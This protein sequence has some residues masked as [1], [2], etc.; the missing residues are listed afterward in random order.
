MH[1]IKRRGFLR[2]GF[3]FSTVPITG[4]G[5]GAAGGVGEAAPAPIAASPPPAVAASAAPA[6]VAAPAPGPAATGSMA[7]SLLTTAAA[8]AA[9]FCIGF[10]FRKGDVP[11]AQSVV[12]D[13]AHLQVTPKNRWPD[14]S[15]KFAVVAGRAALA[16]NT[17]STIALRAGSAAPGVDLTLADLKA[18]GVTAA[19]DGAAFGAASWAGTAWDAP[20]SNWISGPEMSSWIYRKPVGSDAHLVAWLEVRLYAGGAVEVLPWIENGYLKVA[21][22]VNKA[23]VFSFSLGGVLR[24]SAAI[25]LPARA[26]TPLLSG[27]A[28]SHWLGADPAIAARH[29]VDYLQAT[30]AVPAYR[31]VVAPDSA[32]VTGLVATYEPLQKGNFDYNADT[33]S[34]GG[35]ASPIGLLPQHD[36]LYLVANSMSIGAAVQRNGYGAGRY[37][38]HYRDEATN[39]PLRFSAHATT[40]TNYSSTGSYPARATGTAAAQWDVAHSPSVG[41]MAY[42]LSGRYFFMEEVQFAATGNYLFSTDGVRNGADGWFEPV[43]GGVQVRQCAWAFRTLAQ[44][45]AVTPDGDAT[46]QGEFKASVEANI[47]R[48]HSR[49]VAASNNPFGMIEPDYD[50]G[51]PGVY[52]AAGWMQDFFTAAYGYA[53]AM[54]LPISATAQTQLAAFFAWKAQSIIGRLGSSADYWY[55]NAA[56]YN[57]AVA[58]SDT[59]NFGAGTGPWYS[60]W[61]QIYDAT[62]AAAA[63]GQQAAFGTTEGRLSAEILP[64]ADSMWGNLQPAIAYAV[65][66]GV[67]GAAAAY[68]RMTSASNWPALAAQLNA[69]PVW[70]VKPLQ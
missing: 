45:L 56:T 30:E 67:A 34:S 48:F 18:A 55:L 62:A 31:A 42:L 70:S 43:P 47:A 68:Q 9:P 20:F 59:P 16:A 49:Y 41:Y 36:A 44:A 8:D 21:N 15:L 46:M 57:V 52:M 26:R 3:A 32:L 63:S 61:K 19:V 29:D 53:L 13:I 25:D 10:T 11:S 37:P 12:G 39:R 14:G 22:P 4:C 60:S 23:A 54:G 65:R 58:P 33:M 2:L 35:Y 1:D 51:V 28:L 69:V 50:Y 66:H 64:G 40:S 5:G 27:A 6:P 38:V 24:F 7:F 17:T